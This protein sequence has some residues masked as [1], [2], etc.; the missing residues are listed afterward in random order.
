[1]KDTRVRH[2]TTARGLAA[3]AATGVVFAALLTPM[4]SAGETDG[5]AQSAQSAKSEKSAPKP[6]VVL[7]HG[8]FA[9]S[10]GW[11]GV[12]QR[13]QWRGYPVVAVANP[14]RGLPTDSAYLAG[15]LRNL[16]GPVVLVGHSYGGAVI[17]SAAAGMPNVK[18]LVYVAAFMPDKGEVLGEL[19]A[20]FPGSELQPALN[21]LPFSNADGSQ[22]LELTIKPDKFRSVFAADLPRRT[23]SVMAATQRPLSASSFTDVPQAAAWRTIPSWALVAAQDKAIA[24]DLERFE[25]RRAGSRTVEV[26]SSHAVMVSHPD[27]VT[28]LITTAARATAR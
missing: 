7:V 1:M 18:A 16:D 26:N 11:G 2:L 9:D 5:T 6:T 23:T 17:S 12:V 14:L 8:A 4:A 20:K 28:A 13:L 3:L 10:S 22:G 15:V 24:P 21:T 19:A 25:A 27:A